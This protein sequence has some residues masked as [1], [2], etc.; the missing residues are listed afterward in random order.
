V[1]RR[2]LMFAALACAAGVF[3]IGGCSQTTNGLPQAGGDTTSAKPTASSPTAPTSASS[4]SGSSADPCAL[5]SASDLTTLGLDPGKLKKLA[6]NVSFCLWNGPSSDVGF[7]IGYVKNSLAGLGG[8]KIQAG[9]QHE[10]ARVPTVSQLVPSGGCG[11]GLEL[12]DKTTLIVVGSS[13]SGKP[14]ESVCPNVTQV[15]KIIDPKLP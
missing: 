7:A 11:I 14:D 8:S 5:L 6:A 9:T 4:G 15:A 13:R 3:L 10:A 12:P 2:P 1:T